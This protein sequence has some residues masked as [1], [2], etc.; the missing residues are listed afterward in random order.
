MDWAESK[1]IW[2]LRPEFAEVFVGCE[3]FECLE[4][5]N[6]VAGFE[7]VVPVRF[8]LIVGVVK[9]SLHGR[10]LDGSVHALDLSVR[11]R[12]V[13]LGQPVFDSADMAG[14]VEGMTPEACGWPLAVPRSIGKV[15]AVIGEHGMDVV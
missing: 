14:A 13:G 15:D 7:E 4:S 3:A 9:V 10:V 1:S 2:G 6:E 11:P 12:M 5:S 8:E